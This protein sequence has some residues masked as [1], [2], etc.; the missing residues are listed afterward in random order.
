MP[1]T[2]EPMIAQVQQQF[3]GVVAYVT[4]PETRPAPAYAGAL[5]LVRRLLALG[6]AL[7]RL[8]FVTRAAVRPAGPVHSPDGTPLA[9]HDRRRTTCSSVFGKLAFH[10]HAST[11][12]HQPVVCPLDA[13]LRL[14][15][16][17]YSD[18]LRERLS[19][20]TTAESYRESQPVLARPP[21]LPLSLQALEATMA[22]AAVDVATVY[23]QPPG[24][25]APAAAGP[26]L[27]AQA[28]GKGV[29]LVPDTPRPPPRRP[30]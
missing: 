17:C 14:P 23:D 4:G 26:I 19:Y 22:E 8:V 27:V 20:G 12:P 25:A 24:P 6:T 15:A 7:L 2:A 10:R 9:Y 30:W 3:Q 18:R 16:R 5:T 1:S 28:E 13:A 21:G 11:A 29:P